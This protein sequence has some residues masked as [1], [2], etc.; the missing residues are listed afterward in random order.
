MDYVLEVE[1]LSKKFDDFQLKDISFKLKPGYIMGFIGA[2][3]SGKT[4]TI[5]LI[6]N[7]LRRDAGK[8][9]IFGKDNIGFEKEIKDRIGFVYDDLYFYDDLTIW[10]MKDIIAP[11][12]SRWDDKVFNNYLDEFGLPGYKKI[13]DL[14]KGMKMKFSLSLAL[15][16]HADF[17]IMDEPTAGLDPIV[18]REVLD[19][20]YDIIQDENKSIFFSTH[21]T[22]DLEKIADYITFIDKGRMVFSKA[23]DEIYDNYKLI[24]G[25][26]GL[27]EKLNREEFIGFR[28]HNIGFE[29]LAGVEVVN[30][31]GTTDEIVVEQPSLEDI[32]YFYTK[33]KKYAG[34]N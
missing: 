22:T 11:F 33:G 13:K 9:K 24:K 26:R 29:A 3:G 2:N 5:K 4:T 32:M 30:S 17:I 34:T 15:S 8:V 27:L 16:H 12:Y 21:I 1:G 28:V 6:M 23:I 18:R 10:E 25:D 14:S 19:I 20:L 7:L 31:L